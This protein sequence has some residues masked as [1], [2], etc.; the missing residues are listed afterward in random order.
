MLPPRATGDVF[1][2]WSTSNARARDAFRAAAIWTQERP[3]SPDEARSRNANFGY[4][5]DY[6]AELAG[7][8]NA[9]AEDVTRMSAGATAGVLAEYVSA[10][11][12]ARTQFPKELV[13]GIIRGLKDALRTK[14]AAIKE[15][16]KIDLAGRR[17]GAIRAHRHAV[18][19]KPPD[20]PNLK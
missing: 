5:A 6:D 15:A 14:L 16:A 20:A 11:G 10:I 17:E 9:I 3:Q 8:L 13:A 19:R 2:A 4:A 18:T 1:R 12:S 7:I